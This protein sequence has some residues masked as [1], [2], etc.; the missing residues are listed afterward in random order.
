M[1]QQGRQVVRRDLRRVAASH[2]LPI[3]IDAAKADPALALAS[4]FDVGDDLAAA[5]AKADVLVENYRAGVMDKLGLG[6]DDLHAVN[7]RLVYASISGYGG[8]GPWVNRRAYA[9][10]INAETGM[11]GIQS[12]AHGGHLGND[13]HSH[14][15]VY[16]GMETAAGILAALLQRGRTGLP[17]CH[18]PARRAMTARRP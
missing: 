10:V 3:L 5:I 12:R 9:S 11:T 6:W 14:G 18:P 15:D 7:P 1:R 17:G 16:T 8:T 2:L 13:P 4:S